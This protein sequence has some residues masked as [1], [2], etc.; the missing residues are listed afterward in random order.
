M[1]SSVLFRPPSLRRGLALA[2]GLG[3]LACLAVPASGQP[4]Q[5]RLVVFEGFYRTACS[6]CEAAGLAVNQLALDYAGQPVV[7]LEQPV[8][9][10]LGLRYARWWTAYGQGGTVTLPLVMV[11]SGHQISNGDLD[12]ATVYKGMIDAELRRPAGADLWSIAT[13]LGDH[14]RVSVHVRN[15]AGST[16]T[17]DQNPTIHVLVYEDMGATHTQLQSA[18]WA[19]IASPLADGATTGVVFETPAISPADWTKVHVIAL[20][21]YRPGG[22]S[23]P[24]DLLQSAHAWMRSRPGDYDG[25]G[26]PDLAVYRA[27][28]GTWFWLESMTANQQYAYKGWGVQAEGDVPAPGDFDGDGLVD[29]TVFRPASGTWFILESHANYTTWNWFGWGTS[30]D[31][32]MPGDYDGDALTDAAVYRPSTGTWYI[33]PSSGTTPWSVVFGQVGD[34]P[35]AGDFDGDGT[36]DIAVYRAASGTW[37]W[38]KSS[39]DFTTFDYRGWGVQAEG[40]RPAPGDYDGDGKT[41]LCVFRPGVGTWFILESHANQMTWNWF[42]W[43]TSTDTLAPADYDGDGKTDAAVYRSSTGTWFVRPSNAASPWTV[44]FGQAGDVPV[45]A[46][47]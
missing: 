31:I 32:L 22:A 33:R 17:A 24:Y 13:R 12:F 3:A 16:W 45:K 15:R 43:G 1:S 19:H 46:N 36:R 14:F 25:D 30:A 8:D 4:L 47:K 27:T 39:T 37:F 2:A 23:G 38:L 21:D 26:S 40:D 35:I 5:P 9:G 20:V 29:P 28:T 6:P 42:G 34:E 44:V 11:D 10:P 7:F 18:S 41:D